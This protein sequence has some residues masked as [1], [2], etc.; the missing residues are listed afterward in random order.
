MIR[1]RVLQHDIQ[2]CI[3]EGVGALPRPF[4]A[5]RETPIG[6]PLNFKAGSEKF[7]GPGRDRTFEQRLGAQRNGN[8]GNAGD[9]FARRQLGLNI[10]HADI[11]GAFPPGPR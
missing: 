9:H 7:D 4:E 11:Q 6:V 10:D 5:Q 8:F 1:V 2:H 3:D